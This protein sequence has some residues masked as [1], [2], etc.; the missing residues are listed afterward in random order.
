[1]GETLKV[2]LATFPL[3]PDYAAGATLARA[4]HGKYSMI[5]ATLDFASTA[6]PAV[7]F[8]VVALEAA[9]AS[10]QPAAAYLTSGMLRGASDYAWGKELAESPQPRLQKAMR[11]AAKYVNNAFERSQ[12]EH[13][14]GSKEQV[15]AMED[16]VAVG[17]A[18]VYADSHVEWNQEVWKAAVEGL[19]SG[20]LRC[21]TAFEETGVP[22]DKRA[23]SAKAFLSS[24]L[25]S[26]AAPILTKVVAELPKP[27][28]VLYMKGQGKTGHRAGVA[29]IVGRLF[30]YARGMYLLCRKDSGL[31]NDLARRVVSYTYGEQ[32]QDVQD[33]D[34]EGVNGI[35][36]GGNSAVE[37]DPQKD[38]DSDED[39][40]ED[41]DDGMG[42]DG[43]DDSQ[44]DRASKNHPEVEPQEDPLDAY[45]GELAPL[46]RILHMCYLSVVLI[47]GNIAP[48][49]RV[50][51]ALS[52]WDSMA[53]L[54]AFQVRV[55]ETVEL[56]DWL[57]ALLQLEDTGKERSVVAGYIIGLLAE[58]TNDVGELKDGENVEDWVVGTRVEHLLRTA[59]KQLLPAL[60][61]LANIPVNALKTELLDIQLQRRLDEHT[62]M[63][64]LGDGV[65]RCKELVKAKD[66]STSFYATRFRS[67]LIDIG[68]RHR[69]KALNVRAHQWVAGTVTTEECEKEANGGGDTLED[70]PYKFAVVPSY[71]DAC[72]E[73][74]PAATSEELLSFAFGSVLTG[75]ATSAD[76]QAQ[77]L[78]LV[79]FEELSMAAQDAATKAQESK[80]D[81]DKKRG[82]TFFTLLFTCLK[83]TPL[84]ALEQS[85]GW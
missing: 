44:V 60:K 71:V 30:Q 51:E 12:A 46:A 77:S 34:E 42:Q 16:V 19:L 57:V 36:Q 70:L 74:F 68:V 33:A 59:E 61:G 4:F 75:C 26:L 2:V 6:Q 69:L 48:S 27:F 45:L 25:F 9:T 78:A 29:W 39:L 38:E 11:R 50:E 73:S 49:L 67:I 35:D 80:A 72:I 64:K 47:G 1:M 31:A 63:N 7:R 76:I 3:T 81:V 18:C 14:F 17:L 79:V 20:T 5:A 22:L 40:D 28:P 37:K 84:P 85:L 10:Q 23:A 62:P 66:I 21:P 82:I 54:A 41:S 58:H 24:E 56:E 15:A 65:A 43:D 32:E 83:A 55:P 53:F 13:A 52:L 8:L